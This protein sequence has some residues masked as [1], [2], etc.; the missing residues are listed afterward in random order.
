MY[1]QDHTRNRALTILTDFG[2]VQ[3]TETIDPRRKVL[4]IKRRFA[5]LKRTV[6][7]KEERIEK[8]WQ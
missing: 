3:T 4:A 8:L 2:R 6:N 5:P 1:T 7:L